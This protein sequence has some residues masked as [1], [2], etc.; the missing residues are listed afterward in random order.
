MFLT[1]VGL[2]PIPDRP[3]LWW[4][5]GPLSYKTKSGIIVTAPRGLI[6]DDAS[7]PKLCDWIPEL[8]R[9]GLSRRPGLIHDAV[10]SMGREK[11]KNFA[12]ELLREMCIAEGMDEFWAGVIYEAVR[13]FGQKAWDSDASAETQIGQEGSFIDRASYDAFLKGGAKIYS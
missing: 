13:D 3:D 2:V 6:S 8:D 10:Y 9:Q 5:D 4:L 12:D 11:G 7:I 1:N